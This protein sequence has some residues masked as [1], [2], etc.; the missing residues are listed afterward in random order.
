[1]MNAIHI[2]VKDLVALMLQYVTLQAFWEL[3]A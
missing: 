2:L 1:M 3:L